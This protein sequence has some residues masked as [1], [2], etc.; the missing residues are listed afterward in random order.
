MNMVYVE[1]LTE[2]AKSATESVLKL[3]DLHGLDRDEEML[4]FSSVLM[5][6]SVTGTYRNYKF[7]E[8]TK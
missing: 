4:R 1:A 8:A 2:I 3:A 7:K 5:D 6:M